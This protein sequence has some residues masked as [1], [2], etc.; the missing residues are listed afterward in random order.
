VV[1]RHCSSRRCQPQAPHAAAS[2]PEAGG[3]RKEETVLV[4]RESLAKKGGEIS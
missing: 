4:T 1:G 2:A 3:L